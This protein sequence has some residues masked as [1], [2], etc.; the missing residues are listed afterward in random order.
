[1][2]IKKI[3]INTKI[4]FLVFVC[5]VS[6]LNAVEIKDVFIVSS[7]NNDIATQSPKF[8]LE[9]EKINLYCLVRAN[10]GQKVAY[11]TSAKNIKIG[12]ESIPPTG[13][14]E[15]NESELG[16]IEINWYKVEPYMKHNILKSNEP[17]FPEF[18]YYANAHLPFCS[19]NRGWIGYETIEYKE[20]ELS[21]F[22]DRWEI[23][24]DAHPTDKEYDINNGLGVMRYK[25]KII[26]TDKNGKKQILSTPG[27]ESTDY[28]GITQK[29]HRINFRENNSY[30]GWLSSYFNVPGVFGSVDKQVNEYRGID[31]ADL[32]VAGY[33]KY[34]NK[35]I[36]YTNVKGLISL[37]K[38]II[39][40][41]Y[42]YP[43][44]R[45][46][47]S[48]K[49]NAGSVKIEFG[50]NI[51]LG[52]VIFFDY[53]AE[54]NNNPYGYWDHV[55]IIYNDSGEDDKANGILDKYDSILHAGF[56]EPHL[57]PLNDSGF[58][59]DSPTKIMIMRW[60]N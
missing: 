7:I 12:G 54:R 22:K 26:F 1:M 11:I 16:K 55:G 39:D 21:N 9:S 5:I 28:C 14:K 3:L 58:V 50:K 4:Q 57:S 42:L 38:K 43:D 41:G 44:G 24:A 49:E 8:A 36:Q 35:N 45:I 51:R 27:K 59:T 30:L 33:N 37:L 34:S 25:V 56:A 52:D 23:D 20:T 19:K 17:E 18:E 10:S 2:L 15:W 47:N 60:K 31:C 6:F 32:V 29:V 13:I 46:L 53:P 48:T 40:N